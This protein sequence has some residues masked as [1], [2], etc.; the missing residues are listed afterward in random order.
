MNYT[1]IVDLDMRPAALPRA[2][3]AVERRSRR[4]LDLDAH[5]LDDGRALVR[6]SVEGRLPPEVLAAQLRNQYDVRSVRHMVHE[7]GSEVPVA[8]AV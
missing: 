8:A 2:L 1:L 3:R 6:I 7:S 5:S 4:I